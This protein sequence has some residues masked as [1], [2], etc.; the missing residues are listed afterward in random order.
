M[1]I[2]IKTC[3]GCGG[4]EVNAKGRCPVCGTLQ[5]DFIDTTVGDPV[6]K[7]K[8][9]TNANPMAAAKKEQAEK[10]PEQPKP[11]QKPGSEVAEQAPK[12]QTSSPTV[13]KSTSD[14]E[15]TTPDQK[16]KIKKTELPVMAG[17]SSQEKKEHATPHRQTSTAPVKPKQPVSKLPSLNDGDTEKAEEK[18]QKTEVKPSAT[19]PPEN[20]V[21]AVPKKKAASGKT[22]KPQKAVTPKEM[23]EEV[24]DED[25]EEKKSTF[26]FLRPG[27]KSDSKVDIGYDF[28]EDHFYDDTEPLIPPEADK[29]PI[30]AIMHGVLWT[31]L[32]AGFIFFLMNYILLFT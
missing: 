8:T 28:N 4:T 22:G 26:L 20:K 5:K 21:H 11:R 19:A 29:I 2:Q 3:P 15:E 27:I 9:Y 1:E 24:P 10:K 14:R 31:V 7:P 6:P 16:E 23:K 32:I 18:P 13:T 25:V 17:E 30:S 12:P